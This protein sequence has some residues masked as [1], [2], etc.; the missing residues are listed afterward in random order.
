MLRR[1]SVPEL[2]ELAAG[3]GWFD[4]DADDAAEYAELIST[5]LGTLDLVDDHDLSTRAGP[6]GPSA[7]GSDLEVIRSAGRRP[8]PDED[9]LNAVVRWVDVRAVNGDGV[10]SGLKVGLKDSVSVAGVPLTLGGAVLRGFCPP[11]D[12][13]VTERLLRAGARIT[14]ITNMDDFAFSGGGD[15]SA[16]GPILNP[17]DLRR[18]AGGSSGGSAAALAYDGI[19]DGAIGTDQGGSIR[20]PAA[21]CGVLGLKPTHGLVPYTG[22]AGIDATFDHAGPIARSVD[23]LGRLLL[24][25]A[26]PHESDPRQAATTFDPDTVTAALE[27]TADDFRGVR[28]GLLAEGFSEDDEPRR[29]TSEAVRAV[30][31]RLGDAGAVVAEVSVPE[32]LQGGGVAFA[33]F[34]EGMAATALGGG[35]GYH[36][37]GR[38]APEFAAALNAGLRSRGNELP[39]QIKM[40]ALLGEHLRRYYGG[41]VYAAAQNQR[42]W[43]RAAYDAALQQVD[44]LVL[45]TTP[46]AT[47]EHLDSLGL[48][49]KALR[50]WEPLSNCAQTDMTGHPAISIPAASVDGLPVGVMV[51]GRHGDDGRLIEFASRYERRFGWD[52]AIPDPR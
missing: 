21:W 52:S 49:E 36:W 33:G 2:H 46:Y 25:I 20:V 14:A 39:P 28:I 4:L 37:K 8:T 29:Q 3:I 30:A 6:A 26:G 10:L 44:F 13:V 51:I 11:V 31:G 7:A 41:S 27:S 50:G 34:I 19:V 43:L 17:F 1:I 40:V 35:N 32:H 42:A 12:S 38:Y 23:V 48:A 16:Y 9:P 18:S 47:F 15:S 24:A 5:V 22:I 45:P